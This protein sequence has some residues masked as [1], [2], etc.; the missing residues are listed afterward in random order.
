MGRMFLRISIHVPA[1]K[2]TQSLEYCCCA[3]PDFGLK[4]SVFEEKNALGQILE[5]GC[6]LF[7]GVWE[8]VSMLTQLLKGS[9]RDASLSF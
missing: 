8:E 9:L 7:I 5:M 2:C 1:T 3:K 4:D 6:K